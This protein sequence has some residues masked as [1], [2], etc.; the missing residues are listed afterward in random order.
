[1]LYKH[2]AGTGT[3]KCTDGK[4]M[5]VK[6]TANGGGLTVGKA[7]VKDGIGNF[8]GLTNLNDAIGTYAQGDASFGMVKNGKRAYPDQGT[9][10]ADHR[11]RWPRLRHGLSV[12]AFKIERAQ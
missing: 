11:R 12:G 1:V 3:I 9:A 4:S 6:I 7:K 5:K 2:A 10:H 8:T